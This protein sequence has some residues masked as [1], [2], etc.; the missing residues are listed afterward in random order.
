MN[1][2]EIIKRLRFILEVDDSVLSEYFILGGCQLSPENVAEFFKVDT[3][4]VYKE[5]SDE[6]LT[7]F[8][9]GLIIQRRGPSK[10]GLRNPVALNNNLILKKV[11]IALELEARDLDNAF[12][13]A[14]CELS[15][16]EISSL[17]RKPGTK[18]FVECTDELLANFFSGLSLYFRS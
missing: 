18:H 6:Q 12:M 13:L 3:D 16:H 9:D 17:F 5:C 15:A 2:N 14:D 11:R 10:D 1:N 7:R 8:L 4:T